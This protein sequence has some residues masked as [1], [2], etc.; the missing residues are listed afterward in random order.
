MVAIVSGDAD[1]RAALRACCRQYAAEADIG[2]AV[3]CFE[4][5]KAF[6]ASPPCDLALLDLGAPFSLA[7]AQVLRRRGIPFVLL[8]AEEADAECG[9]AAGAP[10]FRIH[11]SALVHLGYV[12]AVEEKCVR[13]AG[14]ELPLSRLR[15]GALLRALAAYRGA[16][17]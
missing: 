13:A 5:G 7:A 14:R 6:L 4:D 16:E 1:C 12:T 8:S 2:L 15:R 10:F 9:Y 3:S 11:R 17:A